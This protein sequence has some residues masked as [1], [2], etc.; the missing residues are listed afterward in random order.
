MEKIKKMEWNRE[1]GIYFG[2]KLNRGVGNGRDWKKNPFILINIKYI[3]IILAALHLNTGLA[4]SRTI[5]FL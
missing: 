2:L 4:F 3:L 1:T 5:Q